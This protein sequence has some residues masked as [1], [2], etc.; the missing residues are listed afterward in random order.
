MANDINMQPLVEKANTMVKL[1]AEAANESDPEKALANAEKLMAMGQE[2]EK[3]GDEMR[4]QLGAKRGAAKVEVV[5]TPDQRKRI[6]DKTGI[7]METLIVDDQAGAMNKGMPSTLPEQI[8]L[9]ALKEAE[10]RKHGAEADK[11]VRAELDRAMEDIE[12]QGN[13]ELSEQ[14]AKLKADPNFAGGLLKKK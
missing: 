1:A 5:L 14:L 11:I 10:R 12:A 7:A 13:A 8:E 3:M 4:A 9:L 2:M 6:L